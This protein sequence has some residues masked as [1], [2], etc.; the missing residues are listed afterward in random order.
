MSLVIGIPKEKIYE[1]DDRESVGRDKK[2][3]FKYMRPIR[4]KKIE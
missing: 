4:K 3:F 2:T 1:K